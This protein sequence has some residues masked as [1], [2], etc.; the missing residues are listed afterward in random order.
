MSRDDA[1]AIKAYLMSLPPV[2]AATPANQIRFP[3]NQRWG[4][5]FWNLLNNP[6]RRFEPDSSQSAA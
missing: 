2:H 1:L 6:N 3:F 5:I 4:M